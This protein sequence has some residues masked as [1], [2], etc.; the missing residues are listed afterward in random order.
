MP[1]YKCVLNDAISTE[2]PMK[3]EKPFYIDIHIVKTKKLGNY[4][5]NSMM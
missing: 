1:T 2:Q 3:Q 5:N 4:I